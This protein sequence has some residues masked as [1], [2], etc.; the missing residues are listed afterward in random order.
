MANDTK[1]VFISHIHEDDEGLKKLK[2]LVNRSGVTIKDGSINST[3]PNNANDPNYI[4]YQI[5]APKIDW[6]SVMVV[7][8]TPDTKDSPWVN[9]E[10]E[11]AFKQGKRIVGVWEYGS[12]GCEI[13]QA[14][15]EYADAVVGW[16]GGSI[17]D[18]ILGNQ[19]KSE[20]PDGSPG[21]V[22]PIKRH[23]C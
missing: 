8:I 23:P 14:L 15:D 12:N 13:P 11:Y 22:R 3:K 1:H 7:Y 4:K 6:C 19:D 20:R 21:P 16:H 2:D 18:A 9:W 5:L 10:I 17:V